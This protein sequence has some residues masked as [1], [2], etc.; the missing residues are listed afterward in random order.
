[1]KYG[2]VRA[3]L[4]QL[5]NGHLEIKKEKILSKGR[6][7]GVVKG[8][9]AGIETQEMGALHPHTVVYLAVI[10]RTCKTM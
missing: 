6:V 7:F 1:M 5:E 4:T 2:I 9:G 8:F 3:N 10:Q